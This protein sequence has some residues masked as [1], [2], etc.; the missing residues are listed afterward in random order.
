MS[1]FALAGP[2]GLPGP[3]GPEGPEGPQGAQGNPGSGLIE[4]VAYLSDTRAAGTEGGSTTSGSWL[5]W[6]L[7]TIDADDQDII[8]G[9]IASDRFV[10]DPGT[11][12]IHADGILYCAGF[13]KIRL[14]NI[15]AGTT[16]L[17]GLSQELGDSV[18]RSSTMLLLGQI[19][20]AAQTTLEF[21]YRVTVSEAT[22][23]LG[24]AVNLGEVE[25]YRRVK[26]EK[27]A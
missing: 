22:D 20:L 3:E 11:Y 24:R 27:Q 23:G 18:N 25:V 1:S 26:I 14:R 6:P 8:V 5:P 13:G 4:A 17:V 2:Q 15:T 12:Y 21:Q 9:A 7:N 19:V 16:I 10:L